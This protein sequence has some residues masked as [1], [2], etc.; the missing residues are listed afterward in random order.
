VTPIVSAVTL[1]SD[2]NWIGYTV[3]PI[4]SAVTLYKTPNV[5]AVTLYKTPIGS[6]VTLYS[7]ADLVICDVTQ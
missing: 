5:S 1:N 7:D 4:V 2:A 6:A 3:K